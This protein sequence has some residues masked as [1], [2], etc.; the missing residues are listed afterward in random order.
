VRTSELD[1]LALDWAVAKCERLKVARKNRKLFV[2]GHMYLIG[3]PLHLLYGAEKTRGWYTP[4]TEWALG[5]RIIEQRG[6]DL[7]GSSFLG[8]DSSRI[9]SAERVIGNR[10]FTE[11]GECPL[12]AAMRCYVASELGDEIGLPRGI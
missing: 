11:R 6:I 9:W 12:L 8:F 10:I 3:I 5:G 1:G 7:H 4:S 2:T